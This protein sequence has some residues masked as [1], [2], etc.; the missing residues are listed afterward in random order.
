MNQDDI[1]RVNRLR[2]MAKRQGYQ[3]HKTRRIDSRATDYG[4]FTL[5]PAKGRPRTFTTA[6]EVEAFL[7]R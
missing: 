7:T 2:R 3:L 1:V 5:T 4:T 6:D